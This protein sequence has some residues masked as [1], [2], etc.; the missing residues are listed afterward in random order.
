MSAGRCDARSV[1]LL[2]RVERGKERDTRTEHDTH[3]RPRRAPPE[4]LQG[5]FE[6][7]ESCWGGGWKR[8][9]RE[10]VRTRHGRPDAQ[11]QPGHD[12]EP[13]FSNRARHCHSIHSSA[14]YRAIPHR[15]ARVTF[16]FDFLRAPF[17]AR[18][19]P[20]TAGSGFRSIREEIP[21]Q[22]EP[23]PA[24]I[25]FPRRSATGTQLRFITLI[26]LHS[27][28]T[29]SLRVFSR[30]RGEKTHQSRENDLSGSSDATERSRRS[31]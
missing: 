15:I 28:A 24:I 23:A 17:D 12:N 26:D 29:R 4:R 7:W 31:H 16:L 25:Q 11:R 2:E 6:G 22:L 9:G 5:W 13:S 21:L 3:D 8:A 30:V 27:R 1:I 14:L 18:G 10:V 20:G 19:N